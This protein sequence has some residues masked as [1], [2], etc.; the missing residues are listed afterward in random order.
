VPPTSSDS[1]VKSVVRGENNLDP[2]DQGF[3]AC[4]QG[5]RA[6]SNPYPT[7]T[8]PELAWKRGWSEAVDYLRELSALEAAFGLPRTES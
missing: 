2:F 3:T 5:V 7:G 8:A 1:Q 6:C 4:A